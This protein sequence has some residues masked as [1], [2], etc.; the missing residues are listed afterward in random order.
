[1]AV[2]T[3]RLPVS[4]GG[5]GQS[6]V[7]VTPTGGPVATV[8]VR[9]A[10]PVTEQFDAIPPNVTVWFPMARSAKVTVPLR[11]MC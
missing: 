10:P 11:S 8:T 1:M 6:M 2:V 7:K 4:G 3:V 9:E 5:V